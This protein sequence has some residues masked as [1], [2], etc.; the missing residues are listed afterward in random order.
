MMEDAESRDGV[1]ALVEARYSRAAQALIRTKNMFEIGSYGMF[2][3][4]VATPFEDPNFNQTLQEYALG[5]RPDFP[6][7]QQSVALRIWSILE[8]ASLDIAT[9][10]VDGQQE[11]SEFEQ[12]KAPTGELLEF[13]KL[14]KY[15]QA[16]A[17][18][19]KVLA[20]QKRL[21]G[22]DRLQCVLCSLRLRPRSNSITNAALDELH[23]LRNCIAHTEGVLDK[24]L[25]RQAPWFGSSPGQ[26]IALTILDIQK[27]IFSGVFCLLASVDSIQ[28]WAGAIR[29]R[30]GPLM[31]D[32]LNAAKQFASTSTRGIWEARRSS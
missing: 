6:D 11:I 23:A 32:H 8:H 26:P 30:T 12:V 29:P 17:I 24:H 7:L 1:L 19:E 5:Q 27:Y 9:I 16:E 31:E 14:S 4:P 28:K 10:F 22:G 13:M 2:N 21:S 15:E 18:V 20:S 25:I 3:Y